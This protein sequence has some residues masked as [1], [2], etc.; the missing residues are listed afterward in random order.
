MR[1]ISLIYQS[2]KN[3]FLLHYCSAEPNSLIC[4]FSIYLDTESEDEIQGKEAQKP[5]KKTEDQSSEAS[6]SD[7][8]MEGTGEEDTPVEDD[9]KVVSTVE[10]MAARRDKLQNDKLRI[11]ALCSSLLESPEKKVIF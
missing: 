2:V 8:G 1:L 5:M 3:Y 4:E 7:S 10:L 11:G 6:D 9:Q